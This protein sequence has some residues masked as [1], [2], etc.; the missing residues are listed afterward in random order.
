[1]PRCGMR[2]GP[3]RA[4]ISLPPPPGSLESVMST[5]MRAVMQAAPRHI[6]HAALACALLSPVAA[7]QETQPSQP[8]APEM[9]A[10][11]QAMMQ[12][13]QQAGTPGAEHAQLAEH[14][15]GT[16]DTTQT[17]W[18]D[19]EAPPMT[20]TGKS[21]DTAAL[22]G[23]QVHTHYDSEFMGQPYKGVGYMGYDNVRGHYTSVWMDNMSTGM[24]I[25]VGEYDPATSTYTFRGEMADPMNDGATTP[26]RQTVRIV[27][28]DHHVLE[29]YEPRG[30][31]EV[32][33][34]QIEYARAE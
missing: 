16:W 10:E 34:M 24:M 27:D 6:L 15:V 30:G 11:M 4:S 22:D 20:V 18:M 26:I 13:W 17:M 32:R 3:A 9:S 7:A 12:A 8:A 31:E 1:M 29:M 21:D 23:R 2:I 33:T 14:F 5:V 28:A 25:S 19:P